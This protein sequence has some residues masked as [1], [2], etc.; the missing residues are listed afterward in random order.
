M[1]L[2]FLGTS[3]DKPVLKQGRNKRLRSAIALRENSRV[4]LVDC[5]PDIKEELRREKLKPQFLFV[6]HAHPDHIQG[7]PWLI[8]TFR[9]KV[10]L[11]L[12]IWQDLQ[13]KRAVKSLDLQPVLV[14]P[15]RWFKIQGFKESFL[16]VEIRHS[17]LVSTFALVLKRGRRV[18]LFYAPD[19]KEMTTGARS[20]FLRAETLILDGSILSRPLN[21]HASIREQLRW[22]QEAKAKKILFTH[23]GKNPTRFSHNVLEKQLKQ[24]DPRAGVCFDGMELRLK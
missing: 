24:I 23:L 1:E 6:T 2:I 10:Y 4:V 3:A 22:A 13:K 5:G 20:Y 15:Q 19:I 8:S 12:S 21:V 17:K 9:P 18:I 14:T 7:L 11:T 16:F